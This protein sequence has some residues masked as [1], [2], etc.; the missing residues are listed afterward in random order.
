M[1]EAEPQRGQGEVLIE[2]IESQP[3][4]VH[5]RVERL[6]IENTG[7]CTR[8]VSLDFTVRADC[9]IRGSS[10]HRVLVPLGVLR[11]GALRGFD[12]RGPSEKPLP[13]LG[14][15]ENGELA[16]QL[17]IAGARRHQPT[18]EALHAFSEVAGRVV[19][20][21]PTDS[22][23][24]VTSEEIR[25]A[26]ESVVTKVVDGVEVD[27]SSDEERIELLR[28]QL[29][30]LVAKYIDGFL[31]V[32]ELDAEVIGQRSLVKFAFREPVYD[33]R[34][35]NTTWDVNDF[36]MAE[37]TH[38]ELSPP[39][40]LEVSKAQ[41]IGLQPDGKAF[42]LGTH[43][44]EHSTLH[45]VGSAAQKYV[46]ALVSVK[47]TPRSFGAYS[48]AFWG[49]FAL[50]LAIMAGIVV[51]RLRADMLVP[52]ER[53]SPGLPTLMLAA[54][55]LLL[56]WVARTPEDWTTAQI[57]RPARYV[58]WCA[59][60]LCSATAAYLALSFGEPGRTYGWLLALVVALTLL[61]AA[62]FVHGRHRKVLSG[63][64]FIALMGASACVAGYALKWEFPLLSEWYTT[65]RHA[66]VVAR[67]DS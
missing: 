41:L 39:P 13:F 63:I 30:S 6:V 42:E 7:E 11:K 27:A 28:S 17:L 45:L 24:H 16:L 21:S 23:N 33:W 57:L 15:R 2:L 5:R 49:P 54:S 62:W 61:A 20:V 47:L 44:K 12:V 64:G 25:T 26:V 18:D 10:D 35:T 19:E 37:S 59:A 43:S 8:Y 3:Q 50:T 1:A 40:L 51:R 46:S 38:F 56:T 67:C 48:A 55:G 60:S 34:P 29:C 9:R 52:P 58:L 22:D 4:W 65:I 31:M 53:L 66:F 14:K 32:V 36:A